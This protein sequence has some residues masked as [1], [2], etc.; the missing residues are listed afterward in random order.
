MTHFDSFQNHNINLIVDYVKVEDFRKKA[1][2]STPFAD[3]AATSKSQQK[4][5]QIAL[6][7]GIKSETDFVAKKP[8]LFTTNQQKLEFEL[9]EN[10]ILEILRMLAEGKEVEETLA[11]YAVA[12][13]PSVRKWMPGTGHHCAKNKD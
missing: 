2:R 1:R 11:I 3:G 13:N 7:H 6:A 5:L 9:T 12:H 4:F 8:D 10:E